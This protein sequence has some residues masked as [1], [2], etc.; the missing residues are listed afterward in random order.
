[1]APNA[2]PHAQLEYPWRSKCEFKSHID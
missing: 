2:T 1:M